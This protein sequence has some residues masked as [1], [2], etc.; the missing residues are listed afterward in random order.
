MFGFGKKNRDQSRAPVAG[1]GQAVPEES[2]FNR[3]K[4]GLQK[5]RHNLGDGLATLLA[6][7]KTID[8]DLLEELENRLLVAD[9]GVEATSAIIDDL[10]ASLK[11]NQ[12]RDTETMENGMNRIAMSS[13]PYCETKFTVIRAA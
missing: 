8:A 5:T 9:V 2:F 3:L 12:L 11:R 6:G 10:T 7:K 4:A 13:A 1:D